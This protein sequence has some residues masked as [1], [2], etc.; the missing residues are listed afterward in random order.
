M[1]Q[2]LPPIV[3]PRPNG[4]SPNSALPNSTM[5]NNYSLRAQR[6]SN[7]PR[8]ILIGLGVLFGFALLCS[9]GGYMLYRKFNADSNFGGSYAELR[10][11]MGGTVP[12]RVRN[13]A[14]E[15]ML[16]EATDP[17]ELSQSL[18]NYGIEVDIARFVMEVQ[19]SGKSDGAVNPLTR[20]FWKAKLAE[21]V[22]AP[23]FGAHNKILSFEWLVPE[24]EAR[25]VVACFPEYGGAETIYVLY[26][27]R[28]KDEWKLF[29]WRSVLAP[30][31]ESQYW[32]IYAMLP[33]RTD[34]AYGEFTNE[35]FTICSRYDVQ[36]QK[37]I[38]DLMTLYRRTEF[39]REYKS[40][41]KDVL[42]AYLISLDAKAELGPIA[43]SLS[44]DEF[45][46]ALIYK[47][48]SAH[49]SGK[50]ASAFEHLMELNRRI[51]WHPQSAKLAGEFAETPEQKQLAAQWLERSVLLVPKNSE[52]IDAFLAVADR[53][54]FKSMLAGFAKTESPEANLFSMTMALGDLNESKLKWLR[55]VMPREHSMPVIRD[56]LDL[57]LAIER[58]DHSAVMKL[59]PYVLANEAF[60]EGD[61]SYFIHGV[62]SAFVQAA[63]ETNA[64]DQ[65]IA[66]LSSEDEKQQF[67]E[68]LRDNAFYNADT[69]PTDE[70]LACLQSISHSSELWR[71]WRTQ[72]AIAKLQSQQGKSS[73]AFD[74]LSAWLESNADEIKDEDRINDAVVLLN[75]LADLGLKCERW[76]ELA[77]QIDAETLFLLMSNHARIDPQALQKF[78]DWYAAMPSPVEHWLQYY[79]A[80]IAFL[81]GEWATADRCLKDAIKLAESDAKI[82]DGEMPLLVASY[83][84]QDYGYS[85]DDDLLSN[86][87]GL[88]FEYAVRCGM[89]DQLLADAQQADEVDEDWLETLDTNYI[90][91]VPATLERVA[92]ML[93]ESK[94]DRGRE[95]AANLD[96]FIAAASERYDEAVRRQLEVLRTK[97]GSSMDQQFAVQRAGEL[98]MMQ[99]S[100]K[101]L[102]TLRQL[103]RGSDMTSYVDCVAA[104]LAKD[105]KAL[106]DASEKWR[107]FEWLNSQFV[108]NPLVLECLD[109][110]AV[111]REVTKQ[112][113]LAL[114]QLQQDCAHVTLALAAEPSAAFDELKQYCESKSFTLELV[115]AARFDQASTACVV[116]VA[117]SKLLITFTAAQH[118][119]LGTSAEAR[120]IL[121]DAQT[122]AAVMLQN[123]SGN[124]SVT[125][126]EL[127]RGI[128]E[129]AEGMPSSVAMIDA[130]YDNVHYKPGWQQ[131]L[132]AS[133][134]TGIDPACPDEFYLPILAKQDSM[135]IERDGKNFAVLA[136]GNVRELIPVEPQQ[137]ETPWQE[138][139]ALTLAPSL[140]MPQL[141]QGVHVRWAED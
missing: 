92:A 128:T 107:R 27:S 139:K 26:L 137:Q 32:A 8:Y 20:V 17:I 51:G 64:F 54:Q 40:L 119:D 86:W 23:D 37:K 53:E 132:S 66:S 88:R 138:T 13:A 39:P 41:A 123:F 78:V 21:A 50:T 63:T 35:A 114:D 49:W 7:A 44:A 1:S 93:R 98:I 67:R 120:E 6:P 48:T 72:I 133:I 2:E 46:G 127:R 112:Q 81:K 45:A 100:T 3:Q 85:Y 124:G 29:D 30:M 57:Q 24:K 10:E 56:Y 80:R 117:N 68:R 69:M 33:E 130:K 111:L 55:D 135:L 136:V 31:N 103:S 102:D 87:F 84:P 106:I 91:A 11:P 22:V 97:D 38:T 76:Q 62:W 126:R 25:A 28:V 52:V 104:T 83:A 73:E 34:D 134:E 113:P 116:S 59:A 140:V 15:A 110:A 129:L 14:A 4:T 16:T 74:A 115:D 9:G 99:R 105:S 61:F 58:D 109:D 71:A 125:A 65:A 60:R 19:R 36:K 75:A 94:L 79:R 77:K 18:N 101:Y 42:C 96:V 141:S 90:G 89:L 47:A 121:K 43:D 108:S 122:I 5:P 12:D 70:S 95:I 118:F 82:A 131:R